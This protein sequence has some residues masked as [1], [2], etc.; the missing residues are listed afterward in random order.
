MHG[1][2]A[3]VRRDRRGDGARCGV[4]GKFD[5]SNQNPI[6][7]LSPGDVVMAND[8]PVTLTKVSGAD[9]HFSGEGWMPLGWLFDTKLALEFDNITVNTDR[10]M[11]G[12]SMKAK[13]DKT[14][15]QVADAD[16]VT[17]GGGSGGVK[18]SGLN[19]DFVVPENPAGGYDPETGQVVI[20]TTDGQEAGRFDVPKNENREAVF[21]VSV[22]DKDGKVYEVGK[23]EDGNGI[24]IASKAGL[25]NSDESNSD[26]NTQE[27]QTK[28]GENDT[29][30]Y[31]AIKES[32]ITLDGKK[33][34]KV[35]R[36]YGNNETIILP[37]GKYKFHAYRKYVE[38]R[39]TDSTAYDGTRMANQPIAIKHIK[40]LNLL[41]LSADKTAYVKENGEQNSTFQTLPYLWDVNSTK[42]GEKEGANDVEYTFSNSGNYL[43]SIQT[44]RVPFQKATTGA[45][46]KVKD[47][48]YI[49]VQGIANYY[50]LNILILDPEPIYF[51]R[52]DNYNGE[53]GFDN[54]EKTELRNEYENL[55]FK[56]ANGDKISY[57]IP[58]MSVKPNQACTILASVLVTKDYL[59]AL[60]KDVP[61]YT[62]AASDNAIQVATGS[63]SNLKEGINKISLSISCNM[64]FGYGVP[65]QITVSDITGRVV[66]QMG[67]YCANNDKSE[68]VNLVKVYFGDKKP[69][70][71]PKSP[72][73]LLNEAI[74]FL[75]NNGYN[76]LFA[77]FSAGNKEELSISDKEI[78][79]I[80]K[81]F[82][83]ISQILNENGEIKVQTYGGNPE[84]AVISAIMEKDGRFK[85]WTGKTIIAIANRNKELDGNFRTSGISFT[86]TTNLGNETMLFHNGSENFTTYVHEVGHLLG[87][88]HPFAEN[89]KYGNPIIHPKPDITQG[90]TRNFMDY[91]PIINMFWKWQW[92]ILRE[93]MIKKKK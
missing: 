65:K 30:L 42:Y 60:K 1:R 67:I 88:A 24:S 16:E 48:G 79:E 43:L 47:G 41:S 74:G 80:N 37:P 87:L 27:S 18:F 61:A 7:S 33:A 26:S 22:R 89:D 68:T 71:N 64:S 77:E 23:E 15:S 75:N 28:I 39:E 35:T 81:R 19:I 90:T 6:P 3:G 40:D 85:T 73:V 63:L 51:T 84:Y 11:I 44:R 46:G 12:G 58:Y 36:Y 54:F 82:G 69:L 5:L 55:E 10:R 17:E 31:L 56:K 20:Y 45:D 13:H 4:Q 66:G 93:N 78:E 8:F 38:V 25:A 14:E 32:D 21:P 29:S 59:K 53:Y 91:A 72:E 86:N 70:D 49:E 34:E 76:Q 52:G 57:A 92:D 50:K 83:G 62:F 9:G 2:R